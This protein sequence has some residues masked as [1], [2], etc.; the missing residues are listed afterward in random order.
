M[1]KG[2]LFDLIGTT[3]IE[4]DPLVINRCFKLAFGD[5]GVSID[6]NVIRLGRGKNKMEMISDALKHT[7]QPVDLA[8]S[9]LASFKMHLESSMDNFSLNEGTV[10]TIDDMKMEGIVVGIGTG[11]PRDIFEKLLRHLNWNI[12][13]FDY[14][15]IAEE[16]GKGRPEPDMIL[17]MLKEYNLRPNE[18]LKVGDT[19]ADIQEGKNAKVMTAVIL[20]GTQ[21]EKEIAS[22]R[23]DFIIR[24]LN[25]LRN[26]VAVN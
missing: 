17:A 23:P 9:I 10:K 2:V 7:H 11:L 18:F 3:V 14:I 13:Q 5:H 1:I 26:I 16:I 15:G 25:E 6:D 12:S 8:K 20:S 4:K 24:S 21:D 19:I 22:Q